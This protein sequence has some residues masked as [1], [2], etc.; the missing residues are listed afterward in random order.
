MDKS[1]H[2][3]YPHEKYRHQTDPRLSK[4]ADQIVG[5]KSHDHN[6][7]L[8]SSL[9][10]I[11]CSVSTGHGTI[12]SP[13]AQLRTHFPHHRNC[14][15]DEVDPRSHNVDNMRPNLSGRQVILGLCDTVT[16]LVQKRVKGENKVN[17]Q[18]S[19]DTQW[20]GVSCH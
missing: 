14:P 16:V 7:H 4:L 11:R 15:V 3:T 20:A 17:S 5:L 10:A 6:V 18:G 19:L 13:V 2:C 12:F 1:R 9:S 8:A